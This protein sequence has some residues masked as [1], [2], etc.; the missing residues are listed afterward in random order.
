MLT[1]QSA[2]KIEERSYSC[3]YCGRDVAPSYGYYGLLKD[4]T[5]AL[6]SILICPHCTF[7]TFLFLPDESQTPGRLY[8]ATVEGISDLIVEALYKQAR[9]CISIK[10]YTAAVLLCRKILMN[11]A[12]QHGASPGKT[13]LDYIEHLDSKGFVP[14]NGKAWVDK[15]RTTGNEATHEIRLIEEKEALQ[16]LK[17]TEMLLRFCYEFPSML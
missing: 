1:W 3:G 13:F 17:F 14:P 4:T 6:G 15:I 5:T 11:L 16:I 8:G 7:P 10:A 2:T 9:T 12:V